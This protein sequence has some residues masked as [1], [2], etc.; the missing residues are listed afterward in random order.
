MGLLGSWACSVVRPYPPI[1]L[2]P[3]AR[4]QLPSLRLRKLYKKV[5]NSSKNIFCAFAIFFMCLQTASEGAATGVEPEPL[6][7]GQ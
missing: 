1:G 4:A 7:E 3:K 5:I 2:R 6:A